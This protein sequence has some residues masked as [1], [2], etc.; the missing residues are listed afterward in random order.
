MKTSTKRVF[1]FDIV[2]ILNFVGVQNT[3]RVGD[4]KIE[5]FPAKP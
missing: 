5:T 2:E 1:C 4:L 3:A